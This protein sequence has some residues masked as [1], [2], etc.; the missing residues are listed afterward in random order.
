VLL[1]VDEVSADIHV[2]DLRIQVTYPFH[3]PAT[4]HDLSL[5]L[6]LVIEV[7]F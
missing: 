3:P 5:I 6:K 7:S 1:E 2:L 4:S